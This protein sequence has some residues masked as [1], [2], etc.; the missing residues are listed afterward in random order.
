MHHE[1]AE[2][3]TDRRTNGEVAN[4]SSEYRY[5]FLCILIWYSLLLNPL[6]F[7]SITMQKKHNCN[8]VRKRADRH[9]EKRRI[10]A[11]SVDAEDDSKD[12]RFILTQ[13]SPD[14]HNTMQKKQN[15]HWG[16]PVYQQI[17]CWES[18]F[19][20]PVII[21]D[22]VSAM[23]VRSCFLIFNIAHGFLCSCFCSWSFI[24]HFPIVH[25]VYVY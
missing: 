14:L 16:H 22:S 1:E 20:S 21:D 8:E 18:F 19:P 7:Y 9:L 13:A 5:W 23:F 12:K 3:S 15:C 6:L 11:L 25:W 24:F 2:L 10:E 17:A 4:R